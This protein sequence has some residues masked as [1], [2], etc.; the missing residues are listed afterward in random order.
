MHSSSSRPLYLCKRLA[1]E[2]S[3]VSDASDGTFTSRERLMG[4]SLVNQLGSYVGA[5]ERL[6]QTPV[7]L[8]YARHTSRFLTLWCLTLPVSLVGSMGLLVVPVTAFVTWCLFGIQEI[9]LFIEHCALDNGDVFMDQLSDQVMIDVCE[10]REATS[11]PLRQLGTRPCAA[12]SDPIGDRAGRSASL[13]ASRGAVRRRCAVARA[14]DRGCAGHR[15]SAGGGGRRRR[16]SARCGVAG[17][18]ERIKG[19][20][21]GCA[22]ADGRRRCSTLARV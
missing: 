4:L 7:P 2:I 16:R 5:C 19:A 18:A 1:A 20:D 6:L 21:G 10:A 8:N 15:R 13:R 9:G 17:A 11:P 3:G 14:A 22:R 12:V